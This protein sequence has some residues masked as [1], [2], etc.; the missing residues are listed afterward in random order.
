M[1]SFKHKNCYLEIIKHNKFWSRASGALS[2]YETTSKTTLTEQYIQ[3][4]CGSTREYSRCRIHLIDRIEDKGEI[5]HVSPLVYLVKRRR[6]VGRL[7]GKY[8]CS[9]QR[10]HVAGVAGTSILDCLSQSC[11]G[12]LRHRGVNRLD[13]HTTYKHTHT[14]MSMNKNKYTC[15][16]LLKIHV[17]MCG[18]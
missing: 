15:I 18:K 8:S 9:I 4:G 17:K 10:H 1:D 7:C 13:L 16:N 12:T 2:V 6:E 5:L 14:Q 3:S 11:R